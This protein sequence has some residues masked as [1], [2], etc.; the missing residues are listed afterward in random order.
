MCSSQTVFPRARRPAS[1][2]RLN[3]IC[4]LMGIGMTSV[5]H[6]KIV[7]VCWLPYTID[8]PAHRALEVV[9]YIGKYCA[10]SDVHN[11]SM[12]QTVEV[13][14]S[15]PYPIE[16]VPV[17]VKYPLW[18]RSFKPLQ[19]CSSPTFVCFCWC[20]SLRW[21]PCGGRPTGPGTS[22]WG[23]GWTCGGPGKETKQWY[24]LHY[25]YPHTYMLICYVQQYHLKL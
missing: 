13:Q 24:H 14:C 25:I 22:P 15:M 16:W 23:R 7:G 1:Y 8:T 10:I 11:L 6:F 17:G 18:G 19:Y 5:A 21:R 12:Q 4:H 20:H 9:H 3:C 2:Y